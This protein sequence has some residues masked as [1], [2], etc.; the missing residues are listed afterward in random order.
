MG[1]KRDD[2][3][4]NFSTMESNAFAGICVE[5]DAKVNLINNIARKNTYSGISYYG[6]DG[7]YAIKCG[8]DI[9]GPEC[10]V[11]LTTPLENLKEIARS[12]KN[13]KY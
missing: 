11:P 9:I 10:A 7:G 6:N 3:H 2:F 5:D 13:Y 8:V 1:S 4:N 12:T